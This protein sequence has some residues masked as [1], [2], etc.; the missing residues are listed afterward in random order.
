MAATLGERC[1][2]GDL[3][4]CTALLE[5]E[6]AIHTAFLATDGA[7]PGWRRRSILWPL[8]KLLL[9]EDPARA[10]SLCQWTSV[11]GCPENDLPRPGVRNPTPERWAPLPGATVTD[12]RWHGDRFTV[13]GH[14]PGAVLW[15]HD[16][17]EK[18]HVVPL[19]GEV[20]S[21]PVLVDD[22][23]F[24]ATR[25]PLHVGQKADGPRPCRQVHRLRQGASEWT[26]QDMGESIQLLPLAHHVGELTGRAGPTLV[27]DVDGRVV[28][29]FPTRIT[30]ASADLAWAGHARNN[31][32]H[33]Y[34]RGAGASERSVEGVCDFGASHLWCTRGRSGTA[35][36]PATGET[37]PSIAEAPVRAAP[38][39]GW[40]PTPATGTRTVSGTVRTAYGSPVVNAEVRWLT[41]TAG[42]HPPALGRIHS[43]RVV[44]RMRTGADG[45]FTFLDVATAG[46]VQ[47]LTDEGS[48][49]VDLA[50][51]A[52]TVELELTVQGGGWRPEILV[53]DPSGK[54]V[55][56]GLWVDGSA[57]VPLDGQPIAATTGRVV[58]P[59]G[60]TLDVN[61]HERLARVV[62]ELDGEPLMCRAVDQSGTPL[63][64]PRR[65]VDLPTGTGLGLRRASWTIDDARL[66]LATVPNAHTFV[67][68]DGRTADTVRLFAADG[69]VWDEPSGLPA[70]RYTVAVAGDAKPGRRPEHLVVA[71]VELV[72][73]AHRV[74]LDPTFDGPVPT[75]PITVRDP[76]GE[77]VPGV[78][79]AGTTDW[80][81]VGHWVRTT[82]LRGVLEAPQNR[83]RRPTAHRRSSEV[84]CDAPN[85]L[86][87]W[88]SAT[89]LPN[90]LDRVVGTWG[91]AD[92]ATD[93]ITTD[94]WSGQPGVLID[95]P[96][97]LGGWAVGEE[98]VH[99]FWMLD[100]DT[101]VL[102]RHL[103][104]ATLLQRISE[105]Q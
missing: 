76:D 35:V 34:R 80:F 58:L 92:R 26:V 5:R 86:P 17:T 37:L 64:E 6:T 20:C 60:A 29:V 98:L 101:L 10:T 2:D 81:R 22:T 11:P 33:L 84:P 66:H 39:R 52:T 48:M 89:L 9:S 31:E 53:V 47:V 68:P 78:I 96:G 3:E 49:T 38:E 105:D 104:G 30:T 71:E 74:D 40:M 28:A 61:T 97:G 14:A 27:R 99:V 12:A 42:G 93:T 24:V 75:S 19:T 46:S 15:A 44:A 103:A 77:T 102:S 32:T 87:E 73:G 85:D 45:R 90:P 4:A 62:V 51:V 36:D 16:D 67:L 21:G 82:T 59:S 91:T 56:D 69:T 95:L 79:C 94:R 23:V 41:A 72:D 18:L 54:P 83:D 55:R 43:P 70:G 88:A 65:C 57:V 25:G 100:P 13:V 63:L 1:D 8:T 7:V 50:P